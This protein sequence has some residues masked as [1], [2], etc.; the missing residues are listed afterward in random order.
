V[1]SGA[2]LVHRAVEEV[3]AKP[4]SRMQIGAALFQVGRLVLATSEESIMPNSMITRQT[5][6]KRRASMSGPLLFRGKNGA[7]ALNR[8]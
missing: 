4:L 7:A 5:I 2:G 1:S 3:Q 6:V 8:P